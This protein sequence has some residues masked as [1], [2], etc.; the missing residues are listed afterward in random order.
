MRRECSRTGTLIFSLAILETPPTPERF[1]SGHLACKT[2]TFIAGISGVTLIDPVEPVVVDANGQLGTLATG[3]GG[4][5]ADTLDGLDS[6]D[7]LLGS[8]SN[9]FT[10]GTLSF[11]AGTT[12]NLDGALDAGGATSLSLP[13][14]GISGAGSGSGLNA[15]QL[16]G[17]DSSAFLTSVADIWVNTTGDTMNGTLVLN[18]IAGDALSTTA[19]IDLGGNIVKGTNLFIHN[20]GLANTALGVQALSGNASGSSNTAVGEF[21]LEKNTTGNG[22]TAV[23]QQSLRNNDQGKENTALGRAAMLLNTAGEKN[24]AVGF[25]TMAANT[26]GSQ[27]TAV[28]QRALNGNT[29]GVTNTAVGFEA[30]VNN[31]EASQN[32]A[33]GRQALRDNIL[34]GKQ[35]RRRRPQSSPEHRLQQY[36]SR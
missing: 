34:G 22:N 31:T 25:L 9:T 26:T 17:L 1:V 6:A 30:L 10:L 32:T 12:L 11:A 35:H 14:S 13:G 2:T 24:T 23:G 27:N 15:D 16:D 3:G 7:F 21:S 5:D 33:V 18:P 8:S 19:D 20:N 36:R 28:G 4:L 29:T